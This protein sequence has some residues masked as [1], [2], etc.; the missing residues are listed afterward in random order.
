MKFSIEQLI[1][2]LNTYTDF[3]ATIERYIETDKSNV[4]AVVKGSLIASS[5]SI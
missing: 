5:G 3:T 2:S 1:Q 4:W